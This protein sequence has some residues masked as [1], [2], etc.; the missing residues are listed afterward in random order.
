MSGLTNKWAIRA[1]ALIAF[2]VAWQ[3]IG[4][5]LNP[6]I[7]SPPTVVAVRF[8]QLMAST[9]DPNMLPAAT[10]ITLETIVAG[11]IPAVLVGVPVGLLMGRIRT[12]EYALD[13]YVNLIYAVPI[14]VMIPILEV[15]FGSSLTTSYTLVFISGVFPIV[16]NTMAGAKNIGTSLL[17]TGRSFGFSGPRMWQKVTFPASLPY[18][19][20]GLRIGIGHCVIGAIL[21]EI[22]MY[23]VGLGYLIENYSAVF[24]TAAAI[25]AVI[26]TILLGIIMTAVVQVFEKRVVMW[27]ANK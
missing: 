1:Y 10:L 16:I 15:W 27:S 19:M 8:R 7:F 11:F 3:I 13:P 25:S 21:A 12:A 24:D 17:E 14:I 4:E 6:L 9:T 20:S 22:L 18:I 2:I 26:V 5:S 23:T